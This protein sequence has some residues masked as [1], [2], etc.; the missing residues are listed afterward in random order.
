MPL[1]NRLERNQLSFIALLV[2]PSTKFV[3]F[4]ARRLTKFVENGFRDAPKCHGS[5]QLPL[6]QKLQYLKA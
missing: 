1:A 3:A 5:S 6:V 4:E 2:S